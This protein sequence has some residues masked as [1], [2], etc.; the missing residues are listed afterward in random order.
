MIILIVLKKIWKTIKINVECIKIKFDRWKIM[1]IILNKKRR[2][3]MASTRIRIIR[4]SSIKI[5]AVSFNR[6]AVRKQN[7]ILFAKNFM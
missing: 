1:S 5:D 6:S 3:L 2:N 7:L 4:L